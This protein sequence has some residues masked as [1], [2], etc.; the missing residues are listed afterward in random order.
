M[1]LLRP[2]AVLLIVLCSIVPVHA[3]DNN[4]AGVEDAGASMVQKGFDL[5]I[6]S[7]ADGLKQIWNTDDTPLRNNF[8]NKTLKDFNT[9]TNLSQK[10]GTTRTS[11]LVFVSMNIEPDKIQAVQVFE[12]KTTPIW[13]LLVI[14]YILCNPIRNVL[15]RAGY[16]TYVDNF[17]VPNLSKEKYIGSVILMACSYATPNVLL[18]IIKACTLAS[19]YMMLNIMDYIEPS[20]SNAWLYLFMAL[21]EAL[22][23]IFFILRPIIICIIYAVCKLLAFWFLSGMWRGEVSWIWTRFWKILTLQP[24][25]IFVTC[26]SIIGIQWSHMDQNPGA[27][28]AMFFM[29][30]YICYKWMTGNFDLPGRMARMTVRSAV[31]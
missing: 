29:L 20:V 13:I 27:Y 1:D 31:L 7:L 12:D 23:S 22:L 24:V 8:D 2:L 5:V 21:S 28:T 16:N 9:N 18:V 26:V 4:T 25:I 14:F 3:A 30:F 10:Y 11:I 17:G 19:A 6:R 15:A